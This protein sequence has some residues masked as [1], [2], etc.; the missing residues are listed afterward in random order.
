[1]E[2]SSWEYQSAIPIIVPALPRIRRFEQLNEASA[3]FRAQLAFLDEEMRQRQHDQPDA[4]HGHA[5]KAGGHELLP[6]GQQGNTDPERAEELRAAVALDPR[7]ALARGSLAIA[8]LRAGRFAEAEE[9]FSASI[10]EESADALAAGRLLFNSA[11]NRDRLLGGL[12]ALLAK[13]PDAVPDGIVDS[14]AAIEDL[15]E[16]DA[17]ALAADAA[18]AVEA[19]AAIDTVLLTPV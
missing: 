5:R 1:M 11:F 8:L 16:A 6:P 10:G 15:P 17:E 12:A 9:A 2:V 3:L 4:R 7:H 13:M 19:S 14:L 18:A